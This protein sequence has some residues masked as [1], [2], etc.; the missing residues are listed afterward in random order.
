[1]KRLQ[2]ILSS[3]SLLLWGCNRKNAP[4]K[5]EVREWPRF[6]ATDNP[7]IKVEKVV[8][9]D[10][11]DLR[12]FMIAPDKKSV[13]V[14]AARSS[15]RVKIPD[16]GKRH[17]GSP[18]FI[19]DDHYIDYRLYH[20]DAE[21]KVKKQLDMPR[22]DWMGRGSF[23]ILEGELLLRV[24]DWFLVLDAQTLTIKE[25]IPVHDSEY[26]PWKQPTMT[27]D[28]YEADYQKRFDVLNK[29]PHARWLYWSASDEY[30]VFVQGETN[31]RSAW[32]PIPHDDE[33]LTAIKKNF[34]PIHV[35]LNPNFT[36][37]DNKGRHF[38][39]SDGVAKIQEVEYLP[40]GTQL[41]YPNYKTR[42]VLQYEMIMGDKKAHFSTTDRDG[43][44]LHLAFS[45]NKML[46][47]ED[48]VAWVQY[49]GGLYRLLASSN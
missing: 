14:L 18:D 42:L 16:G 30:F 23:G 43:H 12:S 24:G 7:E 26:V 8:V 39:I 3:L 33:I 13:Y 11:F 27:R 4:K 49:E 10:D 9:E 19:D 36:S 17:L 29:N 2:F 5:V 15:K 40:G 48:G 32:L 1:M 31:R 47:T 44:D 41:V 46:T 45:T 38:E 37:G 25:K 22:T 21:G 6:P 35:T 34:K 28:E 20:L